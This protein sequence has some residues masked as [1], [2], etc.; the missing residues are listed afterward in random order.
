MWAVPTL[1]VATCHLIIFAEF[2]HLINYGSNLCYTPCLM[3]KFTEAPFDVPHLEPRVKDCS[4][5]DDI[6]CVLPIFIEFF[7][8]CISHSHQQYNIRIRFIMS[9]LLP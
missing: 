5:G 9:R 7:K 1:V 6:V 2:F 3:K 4:N 8:H